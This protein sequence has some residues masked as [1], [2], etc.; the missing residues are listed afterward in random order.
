MADKRLSEKFDALS[1]AKE[2]A[3]GHQ[4]VVWWLV[5][6]WSGSGWRG[7][8]HGVLLHGDVGMQVNLCGLDAFVSEPERDD[9]DADSG[10]QQPHREGVAC[11]RT[12]RVR[13]LP[14]RDWVGAAQG[15]GPPLQRQG[16][17]RNRYATTCGCP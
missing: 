16:L 11:L 13:C 4:V 6:S 14:C 3:K 15:A 8:G 5:S 2:S 17:L 1:N 10:G 12:P 7:W 9:G